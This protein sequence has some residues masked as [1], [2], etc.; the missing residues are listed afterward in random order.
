MLSQC[1]SWTC[2]VHLAYVLISYNITYKCY[3]QL[4]NPTYLAL[5]GTTQHIIL[6]QCHLTSV[7]NVPDQS[8]YVL[9]RKVIL[10]LFQYKR[11]QIYIKQVCLLDYKKK[12]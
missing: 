10:P 2:T 8:K 1:T 12:N 7:W 4:H 11:K 9:A 6:H 3:I 5:P